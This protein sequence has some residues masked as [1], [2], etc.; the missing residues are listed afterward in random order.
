MTLTSGAD[1]PACTTQ[2][3]RGASGPTCWPRC[4]P[5]WSPG[6][7]HVVDA[8]CFLQA[9]SDT[10]LRRPI[11]TRAHAPRRAVH[12]PAGVHADVAGGERDRG[13]VLG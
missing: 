11:V 7:L 3:A 8:P 4:L 12:E 1:L 2:S 13:R 9:P 6:T 5:I 10:C